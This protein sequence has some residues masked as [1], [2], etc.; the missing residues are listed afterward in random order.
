MPIKRF[1][2]RGIVQ[3]VGFRYHVHRFARDLG[4]AGYVRN[5]PDGSVEVVAEGDPGQLAS[6]EASLRQGPRASRVDSVRVEEGPAEL[7]QIGFTIR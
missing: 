2:I 5:R 6:L 4:V 3:G 1:L 7:G